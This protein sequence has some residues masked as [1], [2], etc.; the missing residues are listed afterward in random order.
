MNLDLI[1]GKL[2]E[3]TLHMDRVCAQMRVDPRLLRGADFSA[4]LDHVTG[5]L[6]VRLARHIYKYQGRTL[7]VPRT[8]WDH[9]KL[10]VLKHPWCPRW[11]QKLITVQYDFYRAE[12]YLPDFV[13]ETPPFCFKIMAW[14]PSDTY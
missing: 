2:R 8:W 11:L 4:F 5:D 13:P 10:T 14:R 1:Q 12:V 6:I 3:V 9:L 7:E